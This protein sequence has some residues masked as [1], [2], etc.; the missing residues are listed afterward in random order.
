MSRQ[1]LSQAQE[2]AVR[3]IANPTIVT[4]G[5]GSGKTRTLTHKIAYLV[6]E[7]DFPPDKVLAITF[8]NKAAAEM[9]G[10]LE[11]IT[12]RPVADFPWV[13][14]FHSACF[15]ILKEHCELL[16]YQKPVSIHD[17]SQQRTHLKKALAEFNLD[18]KFLYAAVSMISHAKNSGDPH[19]YLN[20]YGK[21]PRK[22]ELYALYNEM[23]ERSNAVDFDDILLLTRDLLNKFPEI[24]KRYQQ[25][26]DYILIDEFQD[27]NNIQNEIVDLLLRDGNLT[28]VGDDYQSIYKF[29][30]A[31]PLHFINFPQKY[32]QA[33]VFKLEENYRSTAQIVAASDTLI[34]NNTQRME[35]TCFSS[36]EGEL[37][38]VS[39]FP[40]DEAEAE[41]V[42]GK[43]WEYASYEEIPLEEI[44]ILYRTKFTS[45]PFERALRFAR[46]PYSM[47]GAQGFFQRREIQDIHAYL[48]SA[49]NPRDEIAFERILNVPR[50]GIGPA[51]LKKMLLCKEKEMSLQEACRKCT[52]NR[53]LPP[54]TTAA[55]DGLLRF[56]EALKS[57]KPD[58][59]IE[60]VFHEMH[61]DEHLMSIAEN[62]E[63]FESRLE[64]IKQMIFDA[65][66]KG[67]IVEYL[68]DAALLREDQDLSDTRSGVRLSTIHAAKGLEF[69]V[70]FIVALEE[71]ILPHSRSLKRETEDENE[72]EEAFDEGIEEE[73]RL[74]YVAM[75]RASDRLHLT[76]A[77]S[78][79]GETTAP[80]RFLKEIPEL[81]LRLGNPDFI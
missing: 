45:L 56:L 5:A 8:T 74:M 66:R 12:G 81:F 28:V 29:R 65:S 15:K 13:R 1:H 4:A 35:K 75:T 55:L 76:L 80:S 60:R 19:Y 17:D 53:I 43:C 50:R 72:D 79:R 9:K 48:L 26:F 31:E 58:A 33:R 25:N 39:H 70:V 41:W 34:A 64:N 10:R 73:R 78:R 7:L 63:D 52:Q 24:R 38:Q 47:S 21:L 22:R 16:G 49:I 40:D 54:K 67:S 46:V 6:N 51:A 32:H 59:A 20:R 30:G 44:A 27:T 61:Y 3:Y 36:R 18:K 2:A 69:K 77:Q 14:T 37:I 23:L 71:G 68:E 57:E 62:S 11:Q 42:A